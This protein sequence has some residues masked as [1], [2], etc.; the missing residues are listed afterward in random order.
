MIYYFSKQSGDENEMSA[1]TKELYTQLMNTLE[2]GRNATVLSTYAPDGAI[3]KR[4][5]SQDDPAYANLAALEAAEGAVTNGPVTHL[6]KKDG[7]LATAERYLPKSR[8]IILGGGH[9]ALALTEMA[10]ACGFCTLVF[11]DRPMFASAARFP[12]S[13][14]VICDDFSRLFD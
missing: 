4:V 2:A 7:G 10:S 3:T 1:A 13:N 6:R 5:I 14:S 12:A 11:D 9:I 8:L